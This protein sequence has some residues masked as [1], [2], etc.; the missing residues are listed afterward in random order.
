MKS[1]PTVVGLSGV[2]MR[3]QRC[4]GAGT[5]GC[6]WREQSP[7]GICPC[8]PN[9][10]RGASCMK[11]GKCRLQ[12][13]FNEP[14]QLMR[15]AGSYGTPT[16]ANAMNAILKNPMTASACSVSTIP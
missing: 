2:P 12:D 9:T 13:G 1:K 7:G 16:Y 11:S 15:R 14:D 6:G 8:S 10:A 5:E 3:Q 4:H